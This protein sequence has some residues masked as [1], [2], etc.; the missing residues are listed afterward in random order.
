LAVTSATTGCVGGSSGAN[1]AAPVGPAAPVALAALNCKALPDAAGRLPDHVW[2][3]VAFCPLR[4]VQVSPGETP[5]PPSPARPTLVRGDLRP[6]VAA[7]NQPDALPARL[8]TAELRLL[9]PFWVVDRD[10]QAYQ[11]RVPRGPCGEPSSAVTATLKAL[12]G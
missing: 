4:I 5:P 9:A 7:L 6:L 2:V 11:P 3:A 1:R 10:D 8:C 12:H